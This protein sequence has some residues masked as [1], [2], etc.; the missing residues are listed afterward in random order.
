MDWTPPPEPMV[1]TLPKPIPFGSQA[2]STIT[3]HAPT[4]GDILKATA[5]PGAS[6]YD[7]TLRLIACLSAE[8]VPYEALAALPDYLV[9]QMS[10][11]IDMFGG[12]PLPDP[13]E[14]WR[15]EQV[16]ARLAK[17]SPAT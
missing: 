13:L 17:A 10:N 16:A 1:W 3:L 14:S 15:A 9:Q 7:M 8:G 12:A 6:A 11:Y 5:V 4:A 2:Y